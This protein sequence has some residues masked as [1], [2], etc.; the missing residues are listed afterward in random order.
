MGNLQMPVRPTCSRWEN[1]RCQIGISNDKTGLTERQVVSQNVTGPESPDSRTGHVD[2][3]LEAWLDRSQ[4]AR[5]RMAIDEEYRKEVA[6]G[7]SWAMPF[8]FK[9]R[10]QFA[11]S[12]L[13]AVTAV[14]ISAD[15]SPRPPL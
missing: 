10:S 11:A 2:D 7:I 6:R 1:L 4:I 12:C 8:P 5:E 9:L 14:I 13:A 15:F 3:T